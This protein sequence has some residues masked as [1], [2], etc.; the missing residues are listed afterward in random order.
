MEEKKKSVLSMQRRVER[1][2]MKKGMPLDEQVQL[3]IKNSL[4]LGLSEDE[5]IEN[6]MLRNRLHPPPHLIPISEIL[7]RRSDGS[8]IE[9]KLTSV[10][11]DKGYVVE[12][13]KDGEMFHKIVSFDNTQTIRPREGFV[14]PESDTEP[15]E[16]D[17]NEEIA[18]P[19]ETQPVPQTSRGP[20]PEKV[21]PK[22]DPVP[23]PEPEPKPEPELVKDTEQPAPVAAAAPV[24]AKA[25]SF[26]QSPFSIDSLVC[27]AR[28]DG[29]FDDASYHLNDKRVQFLLVQI[30]LG[31]G[32]FK[33]KKLIMINFHGPDCPPMERAKDVQQ[34]GAVADIFGDCHASLTISSDEE[35]CLDHV[36]K[37]LKHVF[38][39]DNGDFSIESLKKEITDRVEEG[40]QQQQEAIMQAAA[41]M[42]ELPNLRPTAADMG[43]SAEDVMKEIRKPLG[44]MNWALFEADPSALKLID[45]GSDSIPEMQS[46]LDDSKVMF[47]IIRLGFGM[48]SFRRTKWVCVTFVGSSIGAVA[49]GKALNNKGELEMML[50]PHQVS[51]EI[52]GSEDLTVE[53]VIEKV[54][55]YVVSD[56]IEKGSMAITLGDFNKALAEEKVAAAS[57]YG[58]NPAATMANLSGIFS[59]NNDDED[60]DVKETIEAIKGDD[61]LLW[62]VF[63]LKK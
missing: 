10:D 36:L 26:K 31:T 13:N 39:S 34:T 63:S 51:I 48:G 38:V 14:P 32:T 17:E 45:A 16:D 3:V 62:G 33:R 5:V 9:A 37:E 44:A 59:A 57:F 53:G 11:E 24:P 54:R 35:C 6:L 25:T 12:W 8:W 52:Q 18:G 56:D 20:S 43:L 2:Y 46:N 22:P 42:A 50:K 15:D 29:I 4:E 7:H 19:A 41:T 1:Y 47:G 40:R 27:D 55:P 60:Y 58:E 49:R 61:P 21:T 23:E 30:P 28:G